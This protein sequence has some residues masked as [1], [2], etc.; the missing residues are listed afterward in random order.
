MTEVQSHSSAGIAWDLADL[1]AGPDDPNIERTLADCLG[2]AET[3]AKKYRGKV[4]QAG[5]TEASVFA[6][7]LTEVESIEER[8]TRAG[9]YAELLYAADTASQPARDLRQRVHQRAVEIENLLLFFLLEWQATTDDDSERILSLSA[10][11][12]YRHHLWHQRR[13]AAH[14]LTEPEE[15]ILNEKDMTGTMA[16]KTLFTETIS[17]VNVPIE[18]EGQT[19]EMTL[20][21]ALA[22]AHRPE[23][24]L[25][26]T[27]HFALY[28]ALTPHANVLT[29][30]YDTLVM[31]KLTMDRLRKFPNPMSSRHL[32]N[33]VDPEVVATML[34]AVEMRY[35]LAHRYFQLKARLLDMPKLMIYDQY[36]PLGLEMERQTYG[37]AQDQILSAFGAFS[38]DIA[39]VARQFYD[40]NWIDAEVRPGKRGGAFCAS[41]SPTLHPYVLCNYLDTARDVMT[42]AHELGHGLHGM[43]ARDQSLYEYHP[44]LALAETASVFA[45]MLV[46]DRLVNQAGDAKAGLA[47]LAHKIED[48]FATIF[49]QTVLTRYE[50][51]AFD[52]RAKGRFRP[53][54]LCE[55]WIEANA[56]YYGEAVEVT[57]AYR[58]GW[59]YIP[60]FIQTPFY[61][62][63]YVFGHLLVLALYR[64]YREQGRSFVPKYLDLLAAGG[65]G[66]PVDLLAPMGIDLNDPSFWSE[67]LSELERLIEQAEQL[68]GAAS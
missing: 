10:V 41:V 11:S 28:D 34:D 12:P 49:R 30:V 36:A 63:A 65:S 43:L 44:S 38:P 56:P 4:S 1:F 64:R 55:I 24:E 66:L 6:A 3:F 16:W 18:I 26:E 58:W 48:S 25:R 19:R 33:Q 39:D 27:S 35:D 52:L 45:E 32:Q 31:D 2:E 22:L 51:K 50:E 53:E 37:Q 54:A 9:A 8:L 61:C 7:A 23:R 40:G 21:E 14:V 13:L 67:G 5:G 29:F 20:M 15:Q 46:F 62:Y 68:A 59:S 42:V 60:H 47:L 57:D 17:E